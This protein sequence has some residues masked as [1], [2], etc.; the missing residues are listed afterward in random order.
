MST[1]TLSEARKNLS[2]IVRSVSE[3]KLRRAV[4]ITVHG[5]KKAVILSV[6]EYEDMVCQFLVKEVEWYKELFGESVEKN[7]E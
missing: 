7:D 3:D 2:S 4:Y 5:Q 1:V 6:D